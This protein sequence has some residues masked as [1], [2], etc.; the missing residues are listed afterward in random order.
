VSQPRSILLITVDC[1]RAD[2]VGFLGYDQ[3]TTPFLD[4]LA[5][6]SVVFPTAIVAGA[7]TYFSF[8][9]IMAGRYPLS[10]GRDVIGLSP[11]EPT[12]GTVLNECGYATAAFVAGNPYLSRRFGYHAGFGVFRDFLEFQAKRVS[13]PNPRSPRLRGRLNRELKALLRKLGPLGSV[14]NELYFQYCQRVASPHVASVDGLRPFPSADR[15]VDSAAQWLTGVAKPFFLWLHL[16][17]PHAPYCPP[18]EAL[19]WMDGEAYAP[20][21]IRYLN[22]YWNR[23]DLR[24]RH[25]S[26]H[27]HE[28]VALYD[29]S[30]RWVDAQIA[31]LVGIL[32]NLDLFGDCLLALT[33]DHGE[34]FLEH[35][36]RYHPPSSLPEEVVRVPL[37]LHVP[38]TAPRPSPDSPFSLLHLAPTLLG[39]AGVAIPPAFEGR[40]LWPQ[41]SQGSSWEDTVV[42]ETIAGCTNPFRHEDRLGPRT[43]VVR[44]RRYKLILDFGCY[45]DRLFDLVA[46]P[47]ERRPLPEDIERPARRRLLEWARV[48]L[49]KSKSQTAEARIGARLQEF[50]QVWLAGSHPDQTEVASPENGVLLDVTAS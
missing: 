4:A 15:V 49:Q 31:R 24:P 30:I 39:A 21:R 27:T 17:D 48:H 12:L 13:G 19:D 23:G 7:P 3:P 41:I 47:G 37:L 45:R 11:N 18:A 33:A 42:T 43:L 8:P 5:K 38:G 29:A 32:R 46:D 35:G 36:R 25:L 20:S 16:M 34:Q 14:Y 22:S 26:R 28:I 2:H 6:Q 9:A 10:L 50:R 40:N 1:L 44:D